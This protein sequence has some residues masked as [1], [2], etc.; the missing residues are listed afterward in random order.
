MSAT[1][2]SVRTGTR[3]ETASDTRSASSRG[4]SSA[5]VSATCA[6]RSAAAH[7]SGHGQVRGARIPCADTGAGFTPRRP[8]TG[9]N[10][11]R[12]R[13]M[14]VLDR[15]PTS[16]DDRARTMRV[17][18]LAAPELPAQIAVDLAEQLPELLERHHDGRWRVALAEEP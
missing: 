15:S 11:G 4:S 6:G 12:Y 2:G 10:R 7:R 13:T 5:S 8:Y 16:L 17:G 3:H 1:A 14:T 18:L 9:E